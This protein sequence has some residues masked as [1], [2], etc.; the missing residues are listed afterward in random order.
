MKIISKEL[1]SLVLGKKV[2]GLIKS[3]TE[4]ELLYQTYIE[5]FNINLDTLTSNMEEWVI[6]DDGQSIGRIT[7][8][9]G[10]HG[11]IIVV[12]I[13][14][15]EVNQKSNTVVNINKFEAMADLCEWVAKEKGLI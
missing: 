11:W 4:N 6:K 8:H 14:C 7:F 12:T 2:T 9:L 3:T 13:F 10:V 15:G 5:V 1:L